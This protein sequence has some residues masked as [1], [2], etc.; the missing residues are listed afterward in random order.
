ME[1]QMNGPAMSAWISRPA[2]V[3]EYLDPRWASLVALAAV[4]AEQ[5]T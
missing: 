2:C 4:Q 5:A 1:E 3:G